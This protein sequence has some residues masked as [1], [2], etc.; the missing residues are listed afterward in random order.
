M[1]SI[2]S[3]N[4][5][6][7]KSVTKRYCNFSSFKVFCCIDLKNTNQVCMELS[8]KNPRLYD[9]LTGIGRKGK[10]GRKEGRMDERSIGWNQGERR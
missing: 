3:V 10:G 9:L 4:R 6:K 5:I 7:G 8:N 1:L 2:N